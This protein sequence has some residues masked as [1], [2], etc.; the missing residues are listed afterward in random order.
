M[1]APVGPLPIPATAK[2]PTIATAYNTGL[3]VLING[4]TTNDHGTQAPHPTSI[5]RRRP[6]RS[7]RLAENI[8]DAMLTRPLS[9]PTDQMKL[10]V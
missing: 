7:H 1:K 6:T 2:V 4:S 9:T 8:T 5:I 10:R 3:P